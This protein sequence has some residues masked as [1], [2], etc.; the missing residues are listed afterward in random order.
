MKHTLIF[1]DTET[2]GI[3]TSDRLI[4]V[5]YRTTDGTD[6]NELYSTAKKIEIAAMAVHHVTE[7]MIAD[8]PLFVNSP[9]YKDLK[10]RFSKDNL[11][12]AHNA[13]FDVAM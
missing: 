2:T 6:V 8:K 1:I 12:I 7:K 13:P 9:A 10:E 5:G 11:F 3:A 4:Q